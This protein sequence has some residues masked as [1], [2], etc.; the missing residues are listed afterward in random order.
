MPEAQAAAPS[1]TASLRTVVNIGPQPGRQA[2]FQ[3]SSADIA[4]Y[5]GAAGGGKSV[6]LLLEPLRHMHNGAFGAV[7]F[8]RTYP[9]IKD[10]GQLWDT[11][12]TIY[13][14]TGGVPSHGNLFWRWPSGMTVSM[15]HMENEA[16][17][18][19]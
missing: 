3:A 8:R 12:E 11:S 6:A 2:Q 19:S 5:G 13:P 14:L 17:R 9:Q 16:D 10:Q 18:F 1:Q 7:I 4:I 15:R